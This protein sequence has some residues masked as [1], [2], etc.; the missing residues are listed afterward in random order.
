M[1]L[2]LQ[3]LCFVRL[4]EMDIPSC[5][6]NSVDRYIMSVPSGDI[7][8]ALAWAKKIERNKITLIDNF[9]H[10][11]KRDPR[12]R[13]ASTLAGHLISVTWSVVPNFDSIGS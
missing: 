13:S 1:I 7:V 5:G 8:C 4:A 11:P 2:P 10:M 6:T 12:I 9:T 3:T